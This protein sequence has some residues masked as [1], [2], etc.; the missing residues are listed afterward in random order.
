MTM[1]LAPEKKA[2]VKE[3][4]DGEKDDDAPRVAAAPTASAPEPTPSISPAS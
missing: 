3:S 2:H 4:K 1:V